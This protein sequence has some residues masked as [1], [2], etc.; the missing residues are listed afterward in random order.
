MLW[1]TWMSWCF[2]VDGH[3]GVARQV[4]DHIKPRIIVPIN[5]ETQDLHAPQSSIAKFLGSVSLNDVA[6]PVGN[7]VAVRGQ[8]ANDRQSVQVVVLKDSPWQPKGDLATL[9]DSMD[10]ACRKSQEVFAELSANQMNWQ[11]PN[12]THTPSLEC[13]AHDGSAAWVLFRD[14]RRERSGQLLAYQFEPSPNAAGVLA[15]AL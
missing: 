7:T 4:I 2:P 3:D 1:Q 12:G 15:R 6:Y 14:L 10:T 9:L 8:E 11:P 13:G 5:Y